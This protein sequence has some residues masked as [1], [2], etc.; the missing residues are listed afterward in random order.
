MDPTKEE[1]R[2]VEIL[3][4]NFGKFLS[5]ESAQDALKTSTAES[6][7]AINHRAEELEGRCD[8]LEEGL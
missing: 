6:F 3:T 8:K 5:T 2:L 1:G 7:L 4:S